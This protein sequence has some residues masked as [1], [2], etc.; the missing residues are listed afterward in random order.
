M[1]QASVTQSFQRFLS[2]NGPIIG[3]S[4]KGFGP[5]FMAFSFSSLA[6]RTSCT[7]S[8]NEAVL[9]IASPF[10]IVGGGWWWCRG[11]GWRRRRWVSINRRS[12]FTFPVTFELQSVRPPNPGR[13]S[14]ST[15][16]AS[17]LAPS[18]HPPPPT[19]PILYSRPARQLPRISVSLFSESK[20]NSS[21]GFPQKGLETLWGWRGGGGKASKKREK[22]IPPRGHQDT[23]YLVCRLIFL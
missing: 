9:M 22:H 19:I 1:L 16:S 5:N 6:L 4:K 21:S 20:L 13:S 3:S 10:P 17:T 14:P 12:N 2:W 11:L 18:R 7:I 15:F 8:W 23:P